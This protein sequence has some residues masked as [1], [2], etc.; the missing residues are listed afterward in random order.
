VAA[1]EERCWPV[2]DAMFVNDSVVLD[3]VADDGRRR[4]DDAP[5]LVAH[6]GSV[7][8]A[9]HLDD[10]AS[11]APAL[12]EALEHAV[13]ATAKPAWFDLRRWSLAR[14]RTPLASAYSFDGVVGLC[15]DAWGGASRVETAWTS[16][17]ELGHVVAARLA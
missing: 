12:L 9:G 14:P 6:S 15:G 17:H 8:A 7:L 10:P 16:G 2:F 1:Y 11:A 5:V 3:L 13:G 4:G